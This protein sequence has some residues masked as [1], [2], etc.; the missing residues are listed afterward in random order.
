MVGSG[1]ERSERINKGFVLE[2][3]DYTE[4]VFRSSSSVVLPSPFSIWIYLSFLSIG[5]GCLYTL[6]R[7]LPA[8]KYLPTFRLQYLASMRILTLFLFLADTRYQTVLCSASLTS[9]FALSSA[10]TRQTQWL[11]DPLC[12][13]LQYLPTWRYSSLL[14]HSLLL[15]I[16]L[17]F[18]LISHLY[19]RLTLCPYY[20]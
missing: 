12:W 9:P 2:R 20:S 3:R 10:R 15:L 8:D 6:S 1:I 4:G 18:R 17:S 16:F 14:T 19:P 13:T 5:Y 11:C 7:T